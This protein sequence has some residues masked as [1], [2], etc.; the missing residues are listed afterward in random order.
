[1]LSISQQCEVGHLREAPDPHFFICRT[2]LL[3]P[4]VVVKVEIFVLDTPSLVLITSARDSSF[5][6]FRMTRGSV[7][8]QL[9]GPHPRVSA[10]VGLEWGSRMCISTK[11]P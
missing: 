11:F 9:A 4:G 5:S 6:G 1:M 2:L 3:I 8:A 7:K 10:C